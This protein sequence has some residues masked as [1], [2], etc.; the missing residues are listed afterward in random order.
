[1]KDELEKD[2]YFI[3][4]YFYFFFMKLLEKEIGTVVKNKIW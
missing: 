1:M 3:L 4:F 2:F